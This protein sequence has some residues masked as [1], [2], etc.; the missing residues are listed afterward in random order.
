ML[1]R[2]IQYSTHCIIVLWI[3]FF[4]RNRLSTIRCQF[5]L[6]PNRLDSNNFLNQFIL[7]SS[8]PAEN[9]IRTN[10]T[11][12]L[13]QNL[14]DVLLRKSIEFTEGI[15][16]VQFDE[17]AISTVVPN[18]DGSEKTSKI[19]KRIANS[20][21][22]FVK[23]DLLANGQTKDFNLNENI[24]IYFQTD[25]PI[26]RSTETVRFRLLLTDANL[27]PIESNCN[28]TIKNHQ[29]VKL[30]FAKLSLTKPYYFA[31]YS[32]DL[33]LITKTGIWNADVLCGRAVKDD[34]RFEVRE[35]TV[36]VMKVD[37]ETP[38]Y[39]L[40]TS[41]SLSIR[42]NATYFYG[43]PVNG[44]VYFSI[45]IKNETHTDK[46]N[47][48]LFC[49]KDGHLRI[50]LKENLF[51][52]NIIS[53]KLIFLEA[54][55][56]DLST[57]TKEKIKSKNIK[58][59]QSPFKISLR[60]LNRF[61]K[62][63]LAN[64]IAKIQQIEITDVD[65]K[66]VENV[67]LD[68][69]IT[70]K[71]EIDIKPYQVNGNDDI[72][73]TDEHG[74]VILTFRIDTVL[75]DLKM[76]IKTIDPNYSD[77][78]Q[79][80]KETSLNY[81][82]EKD[83]ILI[84][85]QRKIF[86]TADELFFSSIVT[87]GD[88]SDENLFYILI[89]KGHILEMS[90]I[91]D[92]QI[93]FYI[94]NRMAPYVRILVLGLTGN[95]TLVADSFRIQV[96]QKQCGVD[97]EIKDKILPPGANLLLK[98]R[99]QLNDIVALN[100]VDQS[101]SALTGKQSSMVSKQKFLQYLERND[102]GLDR[103]GGKNSL[104]IIKNAGFQIFGVEDQRSLNHRKKRIKRNHSS[105][106]ESEILGFCSRQH[107]CCWLA[108]HQPQHKSCQQGRSLIASYSKRTKNECER[109]YFECCLCRQ[110]GRS[111]FMASSRKSSKTLSL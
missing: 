78:E 11:I 42:L 63:K 109:I 50:D 91:V 31:D 47:T 96:V 99:G 83:L 81:F 107:F 3:V 92:K 58:L 46:L 45:F 54:I 23:S 48:N 30:D 67:P 93:N 80:S 70:S 55:I 56:T 24:L 84:S 14:S 8:Q 76:K 43:K 77:S 86:Y 104:E 103:I 89:S 4:T 16:K 20:R 15:K 60:F 34:L 87:Y 111:I 98:L 53:P 2:I 75:E 35:Y 6:V 27:M 61:Y 9:R 100:A 13:D 97:V 1:P 110:R 49:I 90:K 66:P 95:Q 57:E 64:Y 88:I 65:D 29:K 59:V 32:F 69:E 19:K 73:R 17:D 36:P 105:Y 37:I 82:D 28:L 40:Y 44:Y 108:L 18:S 10:I 39:L 101:V 94:T 62:T 72:F 52:R 25:K 85:N 41:Q 33:P 5:I 38:S 102:F 12:G 7:L 106:S 22:L 21:K 71:S 74:L 79:T 68:V 51:S 26:Y